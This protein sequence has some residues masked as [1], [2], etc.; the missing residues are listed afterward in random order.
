VAQS[1]ANRFIFSNWD[2]LE[3]SL[4]CHQESA[5]YFLHDERGGSRAT[6]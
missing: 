2:V 3:D 1:L 4:I 6:H 5:E